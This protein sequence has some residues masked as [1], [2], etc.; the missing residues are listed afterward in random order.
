MAGPD[1]EELL[2]RTDAARQ[3]VAEQR[4]RVRA[5]RRKAKAARA[6]ASAA[7]DQATAIT[8]AARGLLA[9]PEPPIPTHLPEDL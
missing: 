8:L 9:E 4:E 7:R 2:R 6:A 3:R 1:E 5:T